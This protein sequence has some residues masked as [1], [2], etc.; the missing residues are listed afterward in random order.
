MNSEIK[1]YS[2]SFLNVLVAFVIILFFFA[3]FTPYLVKGKV[4]EAVQKEA[5][6]MMFAKVEFSDL[7]IDMIKHFPLIAFNMK[8]IAITGT[9]NDFRNDTLLSAHKIEL[10][11]SPTSLFKKNGYE[12]NQ[13][14]LVSPVINALVAPDGKINWNIFKTDSTH[15]Q[16]NPEHPLSYTSFHLRLNKIQIKDGKI[17]FLDLQSMHGIECLNLNARLSGD[18]FRNDPLL[19]LQCGFDEVSLTDRSGDMLQHVH[20]SFDGSVRADFAQKHF[21]LSENILKTGNQESSLKGSFT[22]RE[23]GFNST[24]KFNK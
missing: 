4:A 13:I 1:N 19:K 6:N 17:S 3:I 12:I 18:L 24:I 21:I 23:D 15:L 16:K 14:A 10:V 7:R 5:E 11:L 8:D 20:T 9:C 2:R 22:I